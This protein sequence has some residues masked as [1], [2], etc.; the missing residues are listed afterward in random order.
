LPGIAV[1]K[2]GVA[3]ARLCPAIHPFTKTLAKEDGCP[4]PVYANRLRPKA[5]FG[6][7]RGFDGP[8][9]SQADEALAKA[10]SPG[11]TTERVIMKAAK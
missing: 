4:G 10:A 3:S 11:M 9:V 8:A 7:S 2:D 1:H 5:D 6:G